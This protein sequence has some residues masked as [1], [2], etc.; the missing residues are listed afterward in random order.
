MEKLSKKMDLKN[1]DQYIVLDLIAPKSNHTHMEVR[2]LLIVVN[3]VIIYTALT[4]VWRA[5]G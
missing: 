2:H 4:L 5:Y 1:T 3:I